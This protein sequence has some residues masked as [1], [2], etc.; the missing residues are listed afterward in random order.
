MLTS[1]RFSTGDEMNLN[2][3]DNENEFFPS[4][5]FGD[6][7]REDF[8]AAVA[9][10]SDDGGNPVKALR[11]VAGPWLK[12]LDR[13]TNAPAGADLRDQRRTQN[14]ALLRALGY[15]AEAGVASLLSRK[16]IP[17][18]ARVAD[19][20]HRDRVWIIE[21]PLPGEADLSADPLSTPFGGD[22]FHAEMRAAAELER[23]LEELLGDEVFGLE[24]A[25]RYVLILGLSQ[26]VLTRRDKWPSRAVLR[27]DLA[28]I[29]SRRDDDILAAFAG[30]AGRPALAPQTGTPLLEHLE[31]E[32]QRRANAV[33]GSLKTTV[34]EAIEI[35]GGEVLTLTG[36]KLPPGR[37]PPAYGAPGTWIDGGPL[38][39]ESLR[40]MYRLL[41]LFYAEANPRLGI[42][43]MKD[44]AYR[45]GYSLEALRELE[46]VRLRTSEERDGTY[47]WTSLIRLLTMIWDGVETKDA[48]TCQPVKVALLDPQSTPLLNRTTPRNEAVQRILR[49]LSL[50][51]SRSG[52]S[53]ISYAQLGIGQLGAVY[54]TLISFTGT[55][56]KT[57]LIELVPDAQSD[58]DAPTGIEDGNEA[59]DP[60]APITPAREERLNFLAP[61]WF[62]PKSRADEFPREK[63]RYV[64]GQPVI[65][66]KGSFLY[67]LAGRDRQKSASYYT[68]EPLARLLVKHTLEEACK[69]LRRDDGSLI[70][71]KL[72][73]LKILEP[74]MGSAAFLVEVT[75]QLAEL[76]LDAKQAETDRTI[77]QDDY[78][79]EKRHVRAYIADRNCFGVDLNPIAVELGAISLWLNSLHAG[80]FSPWFGDQLHAGNSLIGARRAAYAPKD[81]TAKRKGDRWFKLAPHEVT[82]RDPRPADHVWQFLLPA[83]GMAAFDKDGGM[84][85]LVGPQQ[86]AIKAWRRDGW[87]DKL[88]G[89]ELLLAQK[90]SH[91]ADALFDQVADQLRKARADAN[92]AITLWPDRLMPGAT[93]LSHRQK[94]Q[95]F[96]VLTGLEHVR[97]SL[98]Y[99]RLKT[100]MDA[101]SALWLWPLD[102][103]DDLP[104]RPEFFGGLAMLLDG[105][106]QGGALVSEAAASYANSQLDLIDRMAPEDAD[107]MAG[108]L[109]LPNQGELMRETDVDALVAT[110]PWLGVARD[111]AARERFVHFDLIFADVLRDRG[112]FD[113]IVGNP[114]WAKP[115]WSEGDVLG[116]IDPGFLTKQLSAP[117]ARLVR[118]ELLAAPKDRA[119]FLTAYVSAKGAMEVTGNHVMHPFAGGGQNNL[120]RCFVDLAFRLTAP[121]GTAG[122]IH[123]DGHLSDPKSRDFRRHWYRR[124]AKHFHF[125]N[126]MKRKMFAEVH[127]ETAF[128]L[129]VYRGTPQ[130]PHIVKFTEAFLPEQVT[131]SFVHDGNGTLPGVKKPE[132]GWDT[133]GHANR[134]VTIDEAALSAIHALAEDETVPVEET[135]FIQPFSR[136]MMEVFGALATARKLAK[137]IPSVSIQQET[138]QGW[139]NVPVPGW[140]MSACWHETGAQNDGTIRRETSFRPADQTVIQGPLFHV[141]NPIYKTPRAVC[142]SNKAYDVLDLSA[143]SEDYVPR[144]NYGPALDQTDYEARITRCRFNPTR[145]HTDFFRVAIRKMLALNG[146]RTL[147]SALVPTGTAHVDSVQSVAFASSR[148]LLCF[149]A[150]TASVP[151]DFLVKAV[152]KQNFHDDDVASLP[153]PALPDTAKHRALRLACLTRPYAPLWDSEAPCLSAAPWSSADPRLTACAAEAAPAQW[154]RSAAFRTDY[155]RRMA[156]VEIDV[157]VARA[158]G[159]TLAQLQEIYRIYFP[160]L[161]ENEAGTWYDRAGR[162]VWTCSKGLPGVGY[163]VDGKSP[164]RAA[165]NKILAADPDRLECAAT[166]DT[167]PGGPRQVTRVFEGPF[168][169]CD[170]AADYARAWAHFDRLDAEGKLP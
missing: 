131:A 160:V 107:R 94:A 47:L 53:R 130:A 18:L 135:R 31:E 169:R 118:T 63:I 100:A 22:Q 11:G 43:D 134:I 92:D 163:L 81:L 154:D 141:G 138:P 103:V 39:T 60:S 27:F 146:E 127:N 40:M 69:P 97:A 10:W 126:E 54:E 121:A 90:L 36:G 5:A 16:L 82:P 68:P 133:R 115:A 109:S 71:D 145:R 79:I 147:I 143:I 132:G 45:T 161:Q 128:S 155:V 104:S 76:Y 112:G 55:V 89:D 7:L 72:L 83:E 148:D 166:D 114:P 9:R 73:E 50:K 80:T 42:F 35:L 151:I 136:G 77:P 1:S 33:T 164:G 110:T 20:D 84:A 156:L 101:W 116:D 140:Q 29:L 75:N 51:T 44:P 165:W 167:Q 57:D 170:R 117:D 123:Q 125:R 78:E 87:L 102:R 93:G 152:G 24:N 38:A 28:E 168:D 26:L 99:Q 17:I 37:Y 32:A 3:I 162:I 23:S 14:A 150:L 74:A 105:G 67:R 66:P 62:V 159:L 95:A 86:L 139:R 2:G 46:S 49:L 113:V 6:G 158:L 124:A 137:A 91:A 144:S 149:S 21:A 153:F 85:D 34:R 70:A 8:D 48:F 106:F 30:L 120:Y 52:T 98:P 25:P 4:G 96:R 119:A 61:A 64:G 15:K 58:D 13:V 122:L 111:V 108:L 12:M 19:S 56:A 157:L 129:N 142:N 88:S 41:F 65:H 59:D